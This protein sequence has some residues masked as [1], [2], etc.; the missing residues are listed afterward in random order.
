VKLHVLCT[1]LILSHMDL[2]RPTQRSAIC[3][4]TADDLPQF[5]VSQVSSPREMQCGAKLTVCTKWLSYIPVSQVKVA[6]LLCLMLCQVLQG[7]AQGSIFLQQ[8]LLTVHEGVLQIARS[9]ASSCELAAVDP[10]LGDA[11]HPQL[12]RQT[13][14]VDM[15]GRGRGRR[16][17]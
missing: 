15:A 13:I 7:L 8:V 17:K 3:S 1:S 10:C 4:Y 11:I 14:K 16:G 5:T 2:C 12:H 9:D 6:L